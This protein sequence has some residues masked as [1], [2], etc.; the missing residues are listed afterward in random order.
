MD[1]PQCTA[2]KNICISSCLTS[3]ADG[4]T[5]LADR[6]CVGNLE[7]VWRNLHLSHPLNM[8]SKQSRLRPACLPQ[9][10]RYFVPFPPL[11]PPS[12]RRSPANRRAERAGGGGAKDLDGRTAAVPRADDSRVPSGRPSLA[13]SLSLSLSLSP[14]GISQPPSRFSSGKWLQCLVAFRT[15]GGRTF[16]QR[17]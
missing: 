6:K 5:W 17:L 3:I 15:R 2:G 7:N 8:E 12:S 10:R 16:K 11:P 9:S 4:G 13:R 1:A 14:S